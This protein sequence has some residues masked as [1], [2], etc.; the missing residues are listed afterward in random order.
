MTPE[1]RD[2][3][4]AREWIRRARSNLAR[5]RAGPS[6][7]EVLYDDLA[8]DAQQAAEKAAKAVLVHA[9]SSVPRTHSLVELL[10]L[11]ERTGHSVPPD[12]REAGRLTAY[13]VDARYPGFEPV[14][15]VEH[16]EAVV[17]AESVVVWAEA[18]VPRGPG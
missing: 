11:V 9:G 15:A 6:S 4:D 12:V 14:T 16:A 2:P 17:L 8:F 1:L 5:A 13:A 10:D 18:I 7:P 3:T